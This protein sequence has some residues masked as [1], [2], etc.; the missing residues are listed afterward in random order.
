MHSYQVKTK[1]GHVN[2]GVTVEMVENGLLD[3]IIERNDPLTVRF[4]EIR[5]AIIK[6]DNDDD[7]ESVYTDT[8]LTV[9]KEDV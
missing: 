5:S 6:L 8:G 3:A 2:T 7:L 1:L 9:S 4:D